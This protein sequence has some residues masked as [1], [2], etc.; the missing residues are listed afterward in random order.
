MVVTA[1]PL[2]LAS[3][4]IAASV[5]IDIDYRP[6]DEI[7]ANYPLDIKVYDNFFAEEDTAKFSEIIIDH[8]KNAKKEIYIAMYAFNIEEI[9]YALKEA[10]ERGVQVTI[11]YNFE[12][13]SEFDDFLGAEADDF[14]IVW[15]AKNKKRDAH[16]SMHHKFMLV[17]PED[18]NGVVLTGPW[19]WSYFQEDLDPNVLLET[20][21]PE[22]ISSYYSEVK[23]IE[24]G[25]YGYIKFWDFDYIPWSKKITYPNDDFV[26]LWWSP[27]R[28]KNSV[29]TR[30]VD[31][32]LD[33]EETIDVG[34]TIFNSHDISKSLIYKAKE[35]VKVRVIVDRI[36]MDFEDSSI[37][38]LKRKIE[39]NNL[40][41]FEIIRGGTDPSEEQREY[42]IF[43]YHN[44][45]VDNEIVL[46]G[47]ANWTYGGFFLNDENTLIIKNQSIVDQYS[48]MFD[49]YLEYISHEQ[50]SILQK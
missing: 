19:N 29:E 44:L 36:T 26:E 47:T 37:P 30:I 16:Y 49:Q 39:E 34:V 14:N 8:V 20:R 18:E 35:G 43:H 11:F 32:I 2:Y 28:K 33:A 40:S 6:G 22:L 41:N 17:D 12:R 23:R 45:I 25:N 31:L 24:K 4:Q 13:S 48:R 7:V 46:T 3:N 50:V 27:G 38:Y 21:D 1:Y 42:S 15:I 5:I 9:K 10:T